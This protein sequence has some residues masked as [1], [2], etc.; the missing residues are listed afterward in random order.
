[1]RQRQF[2]GARRSQDVRNDRSHS[3]HLANLEDPQRCCSA[4]KDLVRRRRRGARVGVDAENRQKVDDQR[5]LDQRARSAFP[6]RIFCH[7]RFGQP[8]IC[9]TLEGNDQEVEFHEIEIGI[10]QLFAKLIRRSKRP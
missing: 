2:D 6:Q 7:L 10:F 8:V 1:M 4:E 3:R 9:D 5:S